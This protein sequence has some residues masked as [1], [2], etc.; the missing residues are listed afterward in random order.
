MTINLSLLELVVLSLATWRTAYFIARDHAPFGLM[1]RLRARVVKNKDEPHVL[2]CIICSSVW[3]AILMLA[4][5]YTPLQPL[6]WIAAISGGA[7]MLG[8]YTGSSQQ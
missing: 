8:N 7:L 6:V 5:W 3:A 1:K 4:L 2:T